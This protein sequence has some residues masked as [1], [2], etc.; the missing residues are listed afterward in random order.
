MGQE[1]GWVFSS[2][3]LSPPRR[4]YEFPAEITQS[5]EGAQGHT[6]R[7]RPAF[8]LSSG[9]QEPN[10][11]APSPGRPQQVPGTSPQWLLGHCRGTGRC[12]E[13]SAIIALEPLF[14]QH[15]LVKHLV[16]AR[17]CTGQRWGVDM[18]QAGF[19]PAS[20][21]LPS[22]ERYTHLCW[23]GCRGLWTLRKVLETLP[24]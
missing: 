3:A 23:R 5:G 13:F 9:V 7:R 2:H 22:G 16:C 12:L 17:P 18:S 6:A 10:V 14:V 15:I 4:G 19:I 20:G 1:L 21:Q 8:C 11:Q 24:P